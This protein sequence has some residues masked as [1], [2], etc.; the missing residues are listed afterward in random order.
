[1]SDGE[2][3]IDDYQLVNCVATGNVSQVWEARQIS[4]S[5]TYAIKLLLPEAVEDA[6]LRKALKHEATVGKSLEHPFIIRVFDARISRKQAYFLMEYFRGTNLKSLIRSDLPGVHARLPKLMECVSQAF[7]FMHEKNWIHK[8]IKPDNILLTKGGEVRVIDFSLA[9]RPTSMVS[10]L[11]TKKSNVVIQGTRTYI[12]PELIKR[13][14][15]TFAADIYSLGISLYEAL[16]GRSPFMGSNPNELLMKHVRERAEPPSAW[17]PNVSPEADALVLKMLAKR[18]KERHETMQQVFSDVRSIRLFKQ[19]P[20]QYY[21]D[22]SAHEEKSFKASVDQRLDSRADHERT[23]E[24]GHQPAKPR[25]AKPVP[26]IVEKPSKA[27]SPVAQQPAQPQM[28][29][30]MMPPGMMM[31]QMMPP[32]MMMPQMMPPGMMMPQMMPPGMMPPGMMPPPMMPPQMVPP[33]MVPPPAGAP[34]P[35]APSVPGQAPPIPGGGGAPPAPPGQTA[36]SPPPSVPA[37]PQSAAAPSP[38]VR[39]EEDH[40]TTEDL[41]FMTELPDVL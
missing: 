11:T 25:P 32:G 33:Q 37:P 4:T 28:M 5:Q 36:P 23:T 24:H 29:P 19:D 10:R 26:R 15:L 22:K 34:G 2:L 39:D 38:P 1:M 40:V 35:S 20:L 9:S 3:T 13:E 18:P 12:A 6:D 31:P 8:D 17:N 27:S 30:Q 14:P 16:T 41:D 7:A 21:K